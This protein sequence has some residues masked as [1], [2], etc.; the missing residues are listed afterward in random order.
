MTSDPHSLP[1]GMIIKED[2]G[3]R[4]AGNFEN[5]AHHHS[6]KDDEE[7][8]KVFLRDGS[9]LYYEGKPSKI[10][11]VEIRVIQKPPHTTSD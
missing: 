1:M 11:R 6:Q 5:D 10:L 9:P 7:I 3:K 2:Q 4:Q 8:L